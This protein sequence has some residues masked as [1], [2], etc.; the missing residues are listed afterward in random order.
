MEQYLK[1][2]PT[3]FPSFEDKTN[4]R[5]LSFLEENIDNL[6]DLV[7]NPL[8]LNKN[9]TQ[10]DNNANIE[11][12]LPN[13]N[14]LNLD[15]NRVDSAANIENQNYTSR[16]EQNTADYNDFN[17]NTNSSVLG[18]NSN[19]QMSSNDYLSP[20]G[21]TYSQPQPQP[22]QQQQQQQQS[23]Q[24]QQQKS[25]SQSQPQSRANSQ[26]YVLET[27][28]FS[29]TNPGSFTSEPFI[30]EMAFSQ[31]ILG[32]QLS[33]PQYEH[34]Y[35]NSP[36]CESSSPQPLSPQLQ[37]SHPLANSIPKS[38]NLDELISPGKNYEESSF[39]S[40]QYFSPPNKSGNH[41]NSLRSIAEDAYDQN[42]NAD[43]FSPELSRHGSISGPSYSGGKQIP[44]PGSYLSPQLD[45]QSYV[46]PDF[47]SGSYLNSPPQY[48]SRSNKP[49]LDNSTLPNMSTSIPNHG[50]KQENWGALSPP[51]SQ[52]SNLSSSM[53]GSS[54]QI[55]IP[56]ASKESQ[57]SVPTKQLSRDEKLKRRREFHNAVERRRR[58]LIKER[59]KELGMI[60][61]PSLLNPQLCAVQTLQRKNTLDFND[62][63]DLIG[64]IKVKETKPNK[65]TILNKSV[66]YMNHL[67]YVLKQQEITRNELTRQIKLL[68]KELS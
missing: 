1:D 29:G 58:D 22:P 67:N 11:E 55:V 17:F 10:L 48:N 53:P 49:N 2:S 26:Q 39:L 40:P 14:F 15:L 61:P 57:L 32:P 62:L 34:N 54:K 65:S 31:A 12:N 18:Y 9:Q 42:S 52:S 27:D 38:S 43:V 50:I 63:S 28:A 25:Q 8:E 46:S 59:I 13:E 24:Q 36:H 68:E 19:T 30:D 7:Y 4:Q 64:S 47:N 44:L 56:N 51:P 66:V 16:V 6:P 23:Q 33:I 5:D 45:P 20:I 3:E 41:F 35:S 37:H 60:V 21:F